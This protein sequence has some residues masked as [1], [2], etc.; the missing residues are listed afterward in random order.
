MNVEHTKLPGVLLIEPKVYS[1]ARGW[2]MEAWQEERYATV[3]IG[4]QFVQDNISYSE[5]NTVRGLHLQ[6]PKAQG[7]LVQVLYGVVYDV[8]VDVRRGSPNFG[9]WLG[10]NLS[11]DNRNQLWI[12]AGFAHGFC[13]ISEKALL[14][15]K[16]TS[17]YA[18]KDEITIR[19]DDRQIGITWPIEAPLL[20]KKD[21]AGY[22]LGGIDQELLP[23]YDH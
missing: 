5:K 12:P 18:P 1:D 19:Y 7:K 2:F 17:F 11:K 10:V 14:H 15:Y 9:E 21:E 6:H 20:S 23:Q 4:P 22:N 3:G 16:C 13:A 8:V